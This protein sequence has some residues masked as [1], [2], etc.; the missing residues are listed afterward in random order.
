MTNVH[1][2]KKRAQDLIQMAKKEGV[3]S[4]AIEFGNTRF[5]FDFTNQTA[6]EK[7]NPWD[8]KLGFNTTK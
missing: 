3:K 6:K 1:L 2:T 4:G 5:E 8:E 7:L